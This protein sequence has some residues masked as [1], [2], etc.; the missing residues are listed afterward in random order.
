M[1]GKPALRAR[2]GAILA[3]ITSA[4]REVAAS[5]LAGVISNFDPFKHARVVAIFASTRNEIPTGQLILKLRDNGK[6]VLLPRVEATGTGMGFCQFDDLE[7]LKPDR[8]GI[9]TPDGEEFTGIID[10]LLLPGLAFGQDGGRVGY[11]AGF[12][13][14]Y[15]GSNP[16]PRFRCGVGFDQQ[17]FDTVPTEPH[18]VPLTHIATPTGVISVGV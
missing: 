14:R 3:G 13:D 1:T 17:V 15:L 10:L 11:G 12:Y 2:I 16:M 6:L 7:R 4:E 8:F 5:R 18:D 9:R